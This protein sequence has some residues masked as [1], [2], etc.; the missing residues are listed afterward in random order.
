M[1]SH[2]FLPT[3]LWSLPTAF[4]IVHQITQCWLLERHGHIHNVI[5]NIG[6]PRAEVI[7]SVVPGLA[8]DQMG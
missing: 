8:A 7:S 1:Q 2:E 4:T 5:S 6:L 3:G